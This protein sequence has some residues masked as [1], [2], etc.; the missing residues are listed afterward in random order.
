MLQEALKSA[1]YIW[2]VRVYYEDTDAG[3][4]VY[5]ANYL[6]FMER[7]RSEW[8]RALGFDQSAMLHDHD[9]IF[10][11]REVRIEYLKPAR[12][13]DML[14]VSVQLLEAKRSQIIVAQTIQRG[15][16][17]ARAEVKLV[18]VNAQSFK[19]VKIPGTIKLCLERSA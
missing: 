13:D 11:V 6:K 15:E 4:V 19:P 3:G 2:K 18:C 5:Y 7:A 10:V 16:L 1:P 17:L 9:L 12:F 14:D 8:V